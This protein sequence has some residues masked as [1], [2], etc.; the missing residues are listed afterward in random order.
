MNGKEHWKPGD[1]DEHHG[2]GGSYQVVDG[3]RVLVEGS[4]TDMNPK[5]RIDP[6]TG[7]RTLIEDGADGALPATKDKE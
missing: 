5:V 2:Q 7:A 1:I 6:E 3:K 4:R